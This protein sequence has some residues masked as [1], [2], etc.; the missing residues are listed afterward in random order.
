MRLELEDYL[1]DRLDSRNFAVWR[2]SLDKKTGEMRFDENKPW[3]FASTMPGALRIVME[4]MERDS[5]AQCRDLAEAVAAMEAI[6]RRIVK[7][8][9]E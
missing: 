4:A 1:I 8:V 3:R 9:R 6:E 2:K 5:P 7:A